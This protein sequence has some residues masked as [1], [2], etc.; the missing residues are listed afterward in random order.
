MAI[1]PELQN[2]TYTDAPIILEM[3][4]TVREE[5]AEVET[6]EEVKQVED[7]AEENKEGEMD[8]KK[9]S[10]PE[11]SLKM[12]SW[13]DVG[14]ERLSTGESSREETALKAEEVR[15]GVGEQGLLEVMGRSQE[16][17]EKEQ[18]RSVEA[19]LA[20]MEEKW[21]EQ[22]AINETLK[23][24]LANEEERFRVRYFYTHA[25]SVG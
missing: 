24:R 15:G 16:E 17:A 3:E 12:T 2:S 18:T 9:E 11:E 20:L 4:K 14:S 1:A 5:N 22:C 21:K 7:L 6:Q 13:V 25:L 8:E 19:E 23:Q 10:L